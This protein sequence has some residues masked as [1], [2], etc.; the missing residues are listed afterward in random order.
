MARNGAVCA[1]HRQFEAGRRD[2][3]A[4]DA[5]RFEPVSTPPPACKKPAKSR[6]KF[7][8]AGKARPVLRQKA[9]DFQ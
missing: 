4:E 3:L 6:K 8:N 1:N 9:Q 5:A 2:W 7:A